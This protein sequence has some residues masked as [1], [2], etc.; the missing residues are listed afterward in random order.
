MSQ[1]IEEILKGVSIR[2]VGPGPAARV[3]PS[4][5]LSEVYRLFDEE[6]VR[7]VVVVSDGEVQ[8]IFTE[9]DVLRRTAL[10]GLDGSTPVAEVMTPGVTTLAPDQRVADAILAMT[11]KG[12]RHIPVVEGGALLGVLAARDVLRFV[13]DHFPAS[14]LNLPP[15]LHQRLPRPEGG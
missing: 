4:T 5:P 10:E 14:L 2:E 3:A 12:Y 15:R 9:R 7:A 6:R 1:S 11:E 13:A 8:G